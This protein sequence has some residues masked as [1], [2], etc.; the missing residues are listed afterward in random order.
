M[1]EEQLTE[2]IQMVQ[3]ITRSLKIGDHAEAAN[4]TEDSSEKSK[5]PKRRLSI[6]I[7]SLQ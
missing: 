1:H 4:Q 3:D 6:Y 2:V 7:E 5:L